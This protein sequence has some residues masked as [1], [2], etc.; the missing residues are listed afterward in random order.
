[1]DLVSDLF[2]GAVGRRAAVEEDRRAGRGDRGFLGHHQHDLTQLRR[3]AGDRPM[4]GIGAQRDTVDPAEA[5]FD[6]Q[7][8]RGGEQVSRSR[9]IDAR[10]VRHHVDRHRLEGELAQQ[11]DGG[12]DHLRAGFRGG[13]LASLH[14]Q[15]GY[16]GRAVAGHM[17][18]LT[19]SMT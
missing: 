8:I 5:D 6:D 15:V 19:N 4:A 13:S 12:V 7:F 18:K 17:S 1:M 14:C 3:D 9:G 11:L 2:V 16:L 10:L